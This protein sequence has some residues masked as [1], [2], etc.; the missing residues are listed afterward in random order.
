L[1]LRRHL[2]HKGGLSILQRGVP[3]LDSLACCM[4][5]VHF[6]FTHALARLCDIDLR[7]LGNW[8]IAN[9][10]PARRTI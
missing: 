2:G 3:D 4:V 5:F 7:T 8:Y 6:P 9:R 1:T 10:E